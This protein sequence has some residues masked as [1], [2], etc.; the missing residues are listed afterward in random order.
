MDRGAFGAEAAEESG[1]GYGYRRLRRWVILLF[2]KLFS[3]RIYYHF[4]CFC[5]S[6]LGPHT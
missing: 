3:F 2:H 1:R 4:F 5:S 6:M